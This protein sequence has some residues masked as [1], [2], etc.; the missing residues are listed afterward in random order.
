[1]ARVNRIAPFG[2]QGVTVPSAIL[3]HGRPLMKTSF[4]IAGSGLS[5]ERCAQK[6]R[7]MTER[8]N[9]AMRRQMIEVRPSTK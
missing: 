9:V 6:I 7:V 4:R 5:G 1:V 3:K 2:L 8:R